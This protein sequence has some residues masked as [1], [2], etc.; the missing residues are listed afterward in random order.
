M[1]AVLTRN[2][3]GS[4][5]TEERWRRYADSLENSGNSCAD[6]A[7]LGLSDDTGASTG[8]ELLNLGE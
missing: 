3:A 2:P 5:A 6:P 7:A 1:L 8:N 4:S